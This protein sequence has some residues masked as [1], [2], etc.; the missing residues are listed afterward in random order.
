MFKEGHINLPECR[1]LIL[2]L[3]CQNKECVYGPGLYDIL[4]EH[5]LRAGISDNTKYVNSPTF[6]I[7]GTL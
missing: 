3:K 4:W 6:V 1:M 5:H 7:L 2:R